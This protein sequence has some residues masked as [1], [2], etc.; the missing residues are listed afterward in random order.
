MTNVVGIQGELFLDFSDLKQNE[1]S[2]KILKIKSCSKLKFLCAKILK[3]NEEYP[4]DINHLILHYNQPWK[5][6]PDFNKMISIRDIQN[7]HIKKN[8]LL[9]SL[10]ELHNDA[11]CFS[12]N[13]EYKTE[14][15]LFSFVYIKKTKVMRYTVGPS[16]TFILTTKYGRNDK[17]CEFCCFYMK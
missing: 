2:L 9:K 6:D 15:K 7:V 14:N 13:K 11:Y 5:V 3:E 16:G 1:E 10:I 12:C 17:K 8:I 4:E